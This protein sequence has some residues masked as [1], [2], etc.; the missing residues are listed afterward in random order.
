MATTL[1]NL[2]DICYGI[3]NEPQSSQT[4][5]LSYMDTLINQAQYKLCSGSVINFETKQMIVKGPL[6]FLSK[7]KPYA[8]VLPFQNTVDTVIGSTTLFVNSIQGLPTSGAIFIGGSIIT[9]TGIDTMT[10]SLTGIP[11]SGGHSIQYVYPQ[12]SQIQ[13]AYVLPTDYGQVDRLV[14]NNSML[15][16][17]KDWRQI[18][19]GSND[20][21]WA[22]FPTYTTYNSYDITS[23]TYLSYGAMGGFY[24]I[25]E[26]TYFCVFN[27][28][29]SQ[30]IYTLCYEQAA[31][32]L[33]NPND[34]TVVPDQFATEAIPYLAV[35]TMLMQRGEE[36]RALKLMDTVGHAS[37]LSLYEYYQDT[38]GEMIFN[39]ALTSGRDV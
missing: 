21:Q 25:I 26:G 22:N 5:P 13:I 36:D 31:S 19:L 23:N 15:V 7:T 16:T 2:R 14:Y 18:W 32:K 9:Y 35:S 3:I 11:T 39:Q 17:P 1:Q 24:A 10:L 29:G 12:G 30:S 38:S 28:P 8:G 6:P 33:T 4:Y 34:V 27:M 20:S 37:V